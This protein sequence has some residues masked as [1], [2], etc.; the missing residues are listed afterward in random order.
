MDPKRNNQIDLAQFRQLIGDAKGGGY[1][2]EEILAE[3][4]AG[5]PRSRKRGG[6]PDA[7]RKQETGRLVLF[8][9]T[10]RLPDLRDAPKDKEEPEPPPKAGPQPVKGAEVPLREEK[11][12][13]PPPEKEPGGPPEDGKAPSRMEPG[14]VSKFIQKMGRRADDYADQMFEE[15]ESTDPKEVRRLEKLIPGT[16]REAEPEEP[17][18][19]RREKKIEPPPPDLPPKELA[20]HYGKGLKFLRFRALLVFLLAAA[21]VVQLL[22]PALGFIWLPPLDDPILQAWLSVGLLGAGMLLGGDALL[23]GLVRAFRLK[24][25]MDTLTLLACLFTLWDGTCLA[26]SPAPDRFPYCAACLAAVFFLLHGRYH[27]RCGARLACRTAAASSTPY[28]VTLDEKKWNARDTYCKWSGDA[29]GFGSQIQTDD[30]A[31][32]FYRRACP[33]LLL[34]DLLLAALAHTEHEDPGHLLWTLSALFTAS[35]ALGGGLAYGRAFHKVTRRLAR[36]GAAL[37]GWPGISGSRRDSR[38]LITDAD[39]FPTGHIELQNSYKISR[40]FPPERVLAYTATLIRDA[41]SGAAKPFLDELR[42]TGGLPRRAENLAFHEAGGV[43]AVIRGERVLVGTASFMKLMEVPVSQ[44]LNV[45]GAVF[46]AIDGRLAGIF[47]LNYTLPDTVFPAL[48]MLMGEKVGPVLAT[49]DFNLIPAMLRQRFKLA[50]DK[51]DF[52]TVER[53]RELSDPE[54]PHS[55]ALTAL[56]CREGLL[57]FAEAVTAARRLRRATLLGSGLCCAGSALG[58]AL[59]TYLASI[60]AYTSL[61]P[62][63]LL[64]FLLTWLAPVWLLTDWVDRY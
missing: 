47:A 58:L 13:S 59:C 15:D 20:R 36:S 32:R 52:P 44:G 62:L 46:C 33:L 11:P 8:P 43:S 53:R 4:G 19:P 49:R 42:R 45:R 23:E 50:A 6:G 29:A 61:S 40:E 17:P 39:L 12:A 2:L 56:L 30:G 5:K 9:G 3:Y 51:M 37:A 22:C 26:L 41:G 25:G 34:A 1:S 35:A 16:D 64:I 31:Q 14:A 54:S 18:L 55:G 38:V 7:F 57:P 27:K 10:G 48:E 63:N 28:R 24:V 60:S 21:A